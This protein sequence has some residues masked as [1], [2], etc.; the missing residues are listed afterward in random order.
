[1]SWVFAAGRDAVVT[2]SAGAQ[3][4]RVIN[5]DRRF[6]RRCAVAI[7]AD[8]GRLHVRRTSA[9][10]ADAIV[11]TDTVSDDTG[12]IVY[13]REPGGDIMAVV[14]LIAGGNVSGRFTGRL[15]AVVATDAAPGHRGMIHKCDHRPVRGDM[16]VGAFTHGCHV[17]GRFR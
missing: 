2:G 3:H 7:L 1:M 4:L 5:R 11:T 13:G 10:S 16:A 17:V 14:T 12:M 8:V 15:N 9:R 6:E